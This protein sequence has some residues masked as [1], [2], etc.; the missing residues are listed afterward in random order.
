M[1]R[2]KTS[3]GRKEKN[4]FNRWNNHGSVK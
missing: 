3:N 1:L 4:V 2:L